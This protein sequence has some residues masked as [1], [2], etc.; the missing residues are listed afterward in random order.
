[1][2]NTTR[3]PQEPPVERV[4]DDILRKFFVHCLPPLDGPASP[5]VTEGALQVSQVC[6]NWRAV[7]REYGRLWRSLAIRRA[8]LDP[9]LVDETRRWLER[10]HQAPVHFQLVFTSDIPTRIRQ[11]RTCIGQVSDQTTAASLSRELKRKYEDELE[12]ILTDA[13]LPPPPNLLFKMVKGSV[14]SSITRLVLRNIP[15]PNLVRL[16]RRTFPNLERLVLV[17]MDRLDCWQFDWVVCGPIKAFLDC[18]SFQYVALGRFFRGEQ[19]DFILLPFHQ[20]THL[21]DCGPFYDSQQHSCVIAEQVLSTS[22]SLRLFH[23]SFADT[24]GT[25]PSALAESTIV[26]SSVES[27]SVESKNRPWISAAFSRI[28][29]FPNLQ[30]FRF[31]GPIAE[32]STFLE[33]GYGSKLEHVSLLQRQE[34]VPAAIFGMLSERAPQLRSLE[35]TYDALLNLFISLNSTPPTLPHLQ[36]LFIR[37]EG[38]WQA[39]NNT[40]RIQAFFDE[41]FKRPHRQQFR[42]VKIFDESARPDAPA[43]ISGMLFHFFR[44]C[45][46]EAG[47]EFDVTLEAVEGPDNVMHPLFQDPELQGWEGLSELRAEGRDNTFLYSHIAHNL[48]Q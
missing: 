16:P 19:S 31:L 43:Y 45:F 5:S 37:C 28:F 29:R 33:N 44:R 39:V 12:E 13:P 26:S 24:Y 6:S 46:A 1:M 15:I 34:T 23:M 22:T 40:A 42:T 20:I 32:V 2:A 30:S 27:L 8:H 17:C 11:L 48:Q 4:P 14:G 3:G 9:A 35:V 41:D 47:T 38:T 7:T 36:V 10:S 21:I 25:I 18:P